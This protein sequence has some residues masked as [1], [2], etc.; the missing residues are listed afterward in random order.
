MQQS[1]A[2]GISDQV[3]GLLQTAALELEGEPWF[4]QWLR[5][6]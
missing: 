3:K 4:A 1:H 5:T 2:L 6:S